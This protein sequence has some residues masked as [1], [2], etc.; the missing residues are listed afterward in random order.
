MHKLKLID[1]WVALTAKSLLFDV[2]AE[3][4][5]VD[6]L[7]ALCLTVHTHPTGVSVLRLLVTSPDLPMVDILHL[8]TFRTV[9]SKW[10]PMSQPNTQLQPA[11]QLQPNPTPSS[12]Y[13]PSPTAIYHDCNA[14]M[15]DS[16]G[17]S[18][19]LP[20]SCSTCRHPLTYRPFE[21]TLR[22]QSKQTASS[23][24]CR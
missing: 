8:Q 11:L 22:L 7:N 24:I 10:Y 21:R 4:A 5:A 14:R 20:T 19:D 16:S 1:E 12:P 2:D 18:Y 17:S 3:E 23:A 9:S 15:A 6:V 13:P